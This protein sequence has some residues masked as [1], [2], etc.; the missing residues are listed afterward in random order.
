M[1]YSRFN[2]SD[3]S[4][5]LSRKVRSLTCYVCRSRGR[6]PHTVR[7]EKRG[8][9][10]T[11]YGIMCQKLS[12]CKQET[13][14]LHSQKSTSQ[15]HHIVSN[16]KAFQEHKSNKAKIFVATK[17]VVLYVMDLLGWAIRGIPIRP[18]QPVTEA[19]EAYFLFVLVHFFLC[20]FQW[21]FWQAREQ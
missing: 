12:N 7:K 2:V 17:R 3:F 18:P 15:T 8:L 14:I 16:L 20:N 4:W 5:E 13:T 1:L 19:K 10:R 11:L 21:V 9:L 6:E